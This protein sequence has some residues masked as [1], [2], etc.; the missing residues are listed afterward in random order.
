MGKRMTLGKWPRQAREPGSHGPGTLPS[1]LVALSLLLLAVLLLCVPAGTLTCI[2]D[3]GQPVDWFVIYKLPAKCKN[4]PGEPSAPEDCTDGSEVPDG[5]QYKYLDANSGSWQDGVGPISS[6]QGA[7]GLTLSP[8]YGDYT[9][10]LAFLLYNDQPPTTLLSEAPTVTHGHAKGLVLLDQ[11][12]GFWMV[13]SVPRFPPP[14]QTHEYRW[15]SNALTYGQTLL[16]VSFP[17][18]QF[19]KIGKQLNYTYPL[20]Y[21]SQLE[22]N[23]GQQL[24][25]LADVIRGQHV[26]QPPWNRSVTL[27]SRAGATFWSFTKYTKFEDELYAGWL[28][29]TLSSDLQ[30]QFW[31]RRVMPSN[32]S[33][34]YHVF[35]V[36][37]ISFPGG[38]TYNST[39]DHSK[40]CVAS[41]K[42]W[43]CVSDL[44][45][46]YGGYLRSG[47]ALCAQM[48]N[49][50][51]AFKSLVARYQPCPQETVSPDL[52]ENMNSEL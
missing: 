16:C 12:G 17:L 13:H 15:P 51:N 9:S 41:D 32:C 3:S 23:I 19:R 22:G 25:E 35:D 6:Q 42:P 8:L 5:L 24:P 14:S 47:G 45:R 37:Q 11:D 48:P 4:S 31:R 27:T 28:A 43:T 38:P 34:L 2:G 1:P 36:T 21:D 29:A 46:N 30:V 10:Q 7:L 33:G 39:K 40:W 26:Y 50:W 49:L 52:V 44:N 18:A 20:V